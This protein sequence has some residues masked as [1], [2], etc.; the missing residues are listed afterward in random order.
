MLSWGR[1]SFSCDWPGTLWGSL[2]LWGRFDIGLGGGGGRTEPRGPGGNARYR[3]FD[4][5]NPARRN[6]PDGRSARGCILKGSIV[7]V[8]GNLGGAREGR[9]LEMT[10]E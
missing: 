8:N 1:R 2:E 5:A 10:R 6:E 9:K 7:L 4:V 3:G